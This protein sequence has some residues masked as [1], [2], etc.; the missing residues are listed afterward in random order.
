MSHKDL[1]LGLYYFYCTYDIVKDNGLNIRLF[2]DDTSLYLVVEDPTLAAE[3]LNSEL[4][5]VARRA[6]NAWCLLI[7]SKLNLF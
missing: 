5:K 7:L 3:L 4:G 6:N 2:A 1:F